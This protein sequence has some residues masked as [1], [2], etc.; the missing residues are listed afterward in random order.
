MNVCVAV[1]VLVMSVVVLGVRAITIT[2][3]LER[4]KIDPPEPSRMTV[5]SG[6]NVTLSCSASRPWFLCLWVHPAGDKLC[7]IKEDGTDVSVCQGLQGAR[8]VAGDNHCHVT[9]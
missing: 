3:E 6:S 1:R 7:S 4:I 2:R 9:L 8:L 5:R